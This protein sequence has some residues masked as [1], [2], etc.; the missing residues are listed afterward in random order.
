MLISAKPP[1]QQTY[2]NTAKQKP[3][4]TSVLT[5]TDITWPIDSDKPK[6]IRSV[7]ESTKTAPA[8]TKKDTS[9]SA[10]QT[11]PVPPTKPPKKN[12]GNDRPP[13]GSQNPVETYNR[14][15]VLDPDDDE[16]QMITEQTAPTTKIQLNR[17]RTSTQKPP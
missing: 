17:G 12:C 3:V 7:K 11:K 16:D 4:V 5:Q 8:P 6:E 2:A 10:T 9:T 15:K 13:K 14:Y 1:G